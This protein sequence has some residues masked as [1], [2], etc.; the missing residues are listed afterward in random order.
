MMVD[1]YQ[2]DIRKFKGFSLLKKSFISKIPKE[3][4]YKENENSCWNYP[5]SKSGSGYGVIMWGN[6]SYRCN[7]LAYIIFIGLIPK[8]KI[9]RHTCHNR[10]CV[11][12]KHLI[13][14]NHLDNAIDMTKACRQGNQKLNEEAVKVIKWTLKYDYSRGITHKLAKLHGVSVSTIR[15]IK[16]GNNWNWVKI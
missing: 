15:Q 7:R 3:C 11:N 13:L 16:Y 5:I 14:G 8:G 10:A 1:D 4:F 9:I 6:V 12:P 2:L